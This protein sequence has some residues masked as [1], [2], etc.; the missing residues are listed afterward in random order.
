M[1]K[2]FVPVVSHRMG[3]HHQVFDLVQQGGAV[4]GDGCAKVVLQGIPNGS[5][6]CTVD[7]G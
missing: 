2:V 6:F 4:R 5:A 1:H 3:V 7:C